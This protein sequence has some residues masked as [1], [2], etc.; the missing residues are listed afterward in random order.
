MQADPVTPNELRLSYSKRGRYRKCNRLYHLYDDLKI[1]TKK[2]SKFFVIGTVFHDAVRKWHQGMGFD[3]KAA[4][5]KDLDMPFEMLDIQ[6][7]QDFEIEIAK[8]TGMLE[9]YK[10]IYA[11]DNDTYQRI[12]CEEETK[13]PIKID[14]ELLRDTPF[15]HVTY[16]GYL[17]CLMQDKEGNWWIKETKTSSDSSQDFITQA[18]LNFQVVGYMHLARAILGSWPKG[19]IF[20]VVRKATIRQRVSQNETLSAFMRRCIEYYLDPSKNMYKREIVHAD[21]RMLKLWL[22]ETRYE[23]E[24]ILSSYRRNRW[25]MNNEQ[26]KGKFGLCSHFNICATG[27]VNSELFS[28][29][30]V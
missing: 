21:K 16:F 26:C 10:R 20:D 29:K 24:D 5:A 1:R 23:A 27:K 28:Q 30:K 4:I 14:P 13:I 19:V 18:S 9:G 8:L 25:P 15:T 22:R 2:R 3:F 17:D 7:Q 6:A 12:V 11:N